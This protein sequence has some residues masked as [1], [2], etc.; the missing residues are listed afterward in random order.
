MRS[1]LPRFLFSVIGITSLCLGILAYFFL[2]CPPPPLSY[3][4]VL[5]FYAAVL[6]SIAGWINMRH[7][8]L[9][10]KTGNNMARSV[11]RWKSAPHSLSCWV[12]PF[13]SGWFLGCGSRLRC[14]SGLCFWSLGLSVYQPMSWLLTNKKITSISGKCAHSSSGLCFSV[15]SF[16]CG[17]R[18]R[19][20]SV[21][22]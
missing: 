16:P 10:F 3:C 6:G 17:R 22:T 13:R 21:I 9:W 20:C 11:K 15:L 7:L 18:L 4:L 12:L 5:V 2:F 19:N 8:V 14:L 1:S